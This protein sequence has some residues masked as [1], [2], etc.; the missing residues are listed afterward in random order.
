MNSIH[1]FVALLLSSQAFSQVSFDSNF[2][3]LMVDDKPVGDYRS[4]QNLFKWVND[5]RE[6]QIISASNI[7]YF[8]LHPNQPSKSN[9]KADINVRLVNKKD[10]SIIRLYQYLDSKRLFILK[11][12]PD[13]TPSQ[14]F[15]AYILE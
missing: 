13:G 9:S 14:Y 6:F 8:S 1:F 10:G 15:M 11:E 4:E 12:N 2:K 7:E 3:R 5:F